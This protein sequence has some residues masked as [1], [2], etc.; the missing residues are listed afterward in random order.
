MQDE[1]YE[2]LAEFLT[3]AEAIEM[4]EIGWED[5]LFY[6]R[7]YIEENPGCF[8]EDFPEYFYGSE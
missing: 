6:M 3:P 5:F 2:A 1:F 8:K 7:D 4:M